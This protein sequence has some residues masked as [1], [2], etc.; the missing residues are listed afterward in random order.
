MTDQTPA[1]TP[2]KKTLLQTLAFFGERRSLVMLGLG[3][4]SG[5]PFMLIFD[6]LSLWLRD[7]GLSLAVIGFFSLATLSFSFKFLW[8]PLI[9]RTKVPI[10]HGWS[11]IA[12]PGCWS[13]RR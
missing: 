3:F 6:T 7:A 12:A 2:Q 8:A 5:L 4:A 11:A 9:D 1:E 10:L 13:A